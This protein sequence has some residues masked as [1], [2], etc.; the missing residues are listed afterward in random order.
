VYNKRSS[1]GVMCGAENFGLFGKRRAIGYTAF[2]DW[3]WRVL[4]VKL[5]IDSGNTALKYA[6]AGARGFDSVGV[7][8][9]PPQQ[10]S[11]A[12]IEAFFGVG[13]PDSV[14]VANVASDEIARQM[15]EFCKNCWGL[16]P[17]Y[18]KSTP[19]YQ[20]LRNGY[21]QPATLGIDR[22][23]AMV[24]AWSRYQQACCVVDG[25]SAVTIDVIDAVGQH[26]GGLILP[27]RHAMLQALTRHTSL[28]AVPVNFDPAGDLLGKN[29]AA[30][31]VSGVN[32]AIVQTIARVARDFGPR[33][34]RVILTGGDA[35][36]IRA[37]LTDASEQIKNLVLEGV[38]ALVNEGDLS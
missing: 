20:S 9:Y 1:R 26:Q 5:L 34:L 30:C 32:T 15:N 6:F 17:Y 33:P 27:G 4:M 19:A 38:L 11:G 16:V 2:I 13:A 23:C 21:E 22:W 37:E 18:L 10:L 28:D 24:G 36:V 3:S 7:V 35:S 8:A 29:T 25:G 14:Y 12:L 31:I